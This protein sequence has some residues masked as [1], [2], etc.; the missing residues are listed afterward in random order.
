MCRILDVS[1]SG[2]YA[3]RGRPECKRITK[4]RVLI[5]NIRTSFEES[6]GTYGA[7]RI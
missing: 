4:D 3:A 7:L 6:R 2:Y 5:E 1:M